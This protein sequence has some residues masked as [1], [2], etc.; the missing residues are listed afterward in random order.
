VVTL[1]AGRRRLEGRDSKTLAAGEN[2]ISPNSPKTTVLGLLKAAEG[3]TR[4][5][6]IPLPKAEVVKAIKLGWRKTSQEGNLTLAQ[7]GFPT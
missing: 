5:P 7:G 1:Q 4:T 3:A 2:I 6:K